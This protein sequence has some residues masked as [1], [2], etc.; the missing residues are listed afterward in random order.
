MATVCAN[1]TGITISVF[2][3]VDQNAPLV[4]CDSSGIPAVVTGH[5]DRLGV[6]LWTRVNGRYAYLHAGHRAFETINYPPRK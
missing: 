3:K 1:E 2:F 5:N 4:A 6:R